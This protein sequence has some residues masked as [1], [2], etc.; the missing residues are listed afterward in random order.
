MPLEMRAENCLCGVMLLDLFQMISNQESSRRGLPRGSLFLAAET[1][2]NLQHSAMG[3]ISVALSKSTE[4]SPWTRGEQRLSELGIEQHFG[5]L[6]I[7][8]RSQ[9]RHIGPPVQE[10]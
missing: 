3:V 10:T 2:K 5:R 4:G 9:R 1:V 6:R 8:D 7:L